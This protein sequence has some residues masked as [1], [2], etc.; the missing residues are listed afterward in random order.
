MATASDVPMVARKIGQGTYGMVTPFGTNTV[1]KTTKGRFSELMINERRI[2]TL[3]KELALPGVIRFVQVVLQDVNGDV[4]ALQ[5][6]M[7]AM[8]TSLGQHM[9]QRS[10]FTTRQRGSV[11]RQVSDGMRALHAVDIIH[12]DLNQDNVLL[13]FGPA[14]QVTAKVADF[15]LAV[16]VTG[17]LPCIQHCTGARLSGR[18][19]FRAPELLV[20]TTDRFSGASDVY[21]YGVLVFLVLTGALD[22]VA[23]AALRVPDEPANNLVATLLT[24]FLTVRGLASCPYYTPYLPSGTL[25]YPDLM[26]TVLKEHLAGT[27]QGTRN[28]VYVDVY[29]HSVQL[30]PKDRWTF[31]DISDHIPYAQDLLVRELD[32]RPGFD[33]AQ[34]RARNIRDTPPIEQ[35]PPLSAPAQLQSVPSF[36]TRPQ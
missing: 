28:E 36:W 7:E 22:S 30:V 2:A 16:R 32:F 29:V 19:N 15:G 6:V 13:R 33:M 25:R 10:T 27:V 18:T 3:L 26:P 9:Q 21:A 20:G 23:P 12:R 31:Q 24:Y 34:A 11:L 17:D 1:I 14:Q 8:D 4:C 35:R 5:M